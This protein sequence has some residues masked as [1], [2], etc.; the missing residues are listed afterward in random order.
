[1]TAKKLQFKNS[2]PL[3]YF[4]FSLTCLVI[5]VMLTSCEQNPTAPNEPPKPY[6]YQEDIYWPSLADSPWPM[7]RAD[8]QNTG[9][10]K[11]T[12]PGSGNIVV[13]IDSLWPASGVAVG[14]DSTI[15]L[16]VHSWWYGY[17]SGGLI[18]MRPDGSIKWHY[19]I[20]VEE[21]SPA[22]SPIIASNGTIYVSSNDI[23]GQNNK[24]LAIK[25]DGTLKWEILL[26][27]KSQI[28]QSGVNIGLDGK[29]YAMARASDNSSLLL[30][31]SPFGYIEWE[32]P[33]GE[34]SYLPADGISFSPDG[35]TLFVPGYFDSK[36]LY[37]VDLE[38]KSIKWTFGSGRS[39]LS[40]T[41]L[42]D[43]Q[44]N[45]YIV[46][47]GE[48]GEGRLYSLNE[49]GSI[50]WSYKLDNI[51]QF[52]QTINPFVMD[53]SGN[54]Y[55]GRDT[56]LCID[57]F[58]HLRWG[59]GISDDQAYYS[60]ITSPIVVDESGELI[61]TV[62]INDQ[63]HLMKVSSEGK[64]LWEVPFSGFNYGGYNTSPACS[65]GQYFYPYNP[66]P[67]HNPAFIILE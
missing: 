24:V 60:G 61:F 49:F 11:S 10:S 15:Y 52:A 12:G 36:T 5:A 7:Y 31:I 65:F 56:L 53:K 14:E 1:M 22:S 58:G 23:T 46:S 21:N 37:A 63:T 33:M 20:Y 3:K 18:A 43:S 66:A 19:P 44:G 42:I 17:D 2:R 48:S 28:I 9:R 29:I 39:S 6:G 40:A 26:N 30:A 67:T 62:G 27:N 35:K 47:E 50:R 8:P 25:S 45:I 38:T 64:L 34:A 13:R 55:I 16:V 54:I 57:Y 51:F 32:L 41:P 59:L 4:I